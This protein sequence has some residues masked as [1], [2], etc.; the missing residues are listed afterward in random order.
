MAF[1]SDVIESIL[2][3]A[4]LINEYLEF[5]VNPS[6]ARKDERA[7]MLWEQVCECYG[8]NPYRT[9]LEARERPERNAH[10]LSALM[11][12]AV[13][14]CKPRTPGRQWIKPTSALAYPLAIIR[15]FSRW[16]VPMPSYKALKAATAGLARDY[17][18]Y[19]GP[20]SLAPR[21]A[22]PMKFAMVRAIWRKPLNAGTSV[23]QVPWTDDQHDVFILRR[24][25]CFL[26][27]T[28]FR[29]AE[30][31]GNGSAEVMYLT[32]QCLTW[33]INGKFI[34]HPTRAELA[35]LVSGRDV[36]F[37]A[38][39][40]SKPDQWGE[41][42]CPFPV[43]LTFDDADDI[44]PAACLRDIELRYGIDAESRAAAPLFATGNGQTYRHQHLHD[45]LRSTLSSLFGAAS[46]SLYTFHSFRSGLAT[47]LHAAGVDDQMIMLICRWMCPESLHVYRRMGTAEHERHIRNAASANV[48]SIQ[49][50]NIVR[51]VGDQSYA[52]LVNQFATV[53]HMAREAYE[54]ALRGIDLDA[55]A[56]SPTTPRVRRTNDQGTPREPAAQALDDDDTHAPVL[57]PPPSLVPL[58]VCPA[59]GDDI[60]VPS[61][62]WPS[63]RC[64]ELQGAGWEVRVVATSASSVVVKFLHARTHH[65]RPYRDERI[66]WAALARVAA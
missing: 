21:R 11:F 9:A 12:H 22:E 25:C 14:I 57:P 18:A 26:M 53:G 1:R 44:N 27:H 24:L 6:T 38:P 42:H 63:Y 29:L 43:V 55:P 64:R 50:P 2:S 36:A 61:S 19:H 23:G 46:A 54:A 49:T 51:V 41:T 58:T 62:V 52:E 32:L 48:D 66:E 4:D 47:A 31:V 28:G 3:S 20:H 56:A 65:G 5:G 7:W 16:H 60:V 17:L 33:R 30:I 8:T 40:R 15:I 35:S 39:P 45:L 59:V 34:T 37:V 13:A 10:L